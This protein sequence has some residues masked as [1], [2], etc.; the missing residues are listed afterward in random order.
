MTLIIIVHWHSGIT[1]SIYVYFYVKYTLLYSS[2]PYFTHDYGRD[3]VP[4]SC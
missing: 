4:K 1:F 3:K 2:L